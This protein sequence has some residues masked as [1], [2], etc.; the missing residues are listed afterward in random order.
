MALFES[1]DKDNSGAITFEELKEELENFPEVMENLTIRSTCSSQSFQESAWPKQTSSR[2]YG[3]K[4]GYKNRHKNRLGRL[5]VFPLEPRTLRDDL[6]E[7]YK[8][9]RGIDKVNDKGLLRR[10]G[11]FKTVGHIFK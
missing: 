4:N 7:V 5:G 8:I 11:E 2:Y 6:I 9:T 10:V 1:A 3:L